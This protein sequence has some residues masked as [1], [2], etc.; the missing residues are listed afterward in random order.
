MCV[1][2]GGVETTTEATDYFLGGE[3]FN[4]GTVGIDDRLRLYWLAECGY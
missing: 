1:A 2:V 3:L 4:R